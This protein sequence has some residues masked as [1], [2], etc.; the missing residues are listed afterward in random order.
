MRTSTVYNRQSGF[1][2]VE[3]MVTIVVAFLVSAAIWSAYKVQ[4]QNTTIQQQVTEIQQ[5]IRAALETMS[6]EFRLVA[7][8]PTNAGE[9]VIDPSPVSTHTT[10]SFTAD[11]CEDGGAPKP[12]GVAACQPG[13]PYAGQV[14][15]ERYRYQLTDLDGDGVND[16][17]LRITD[18]NPLPINPT[19][20]IAENIE[21]VEFMY[22]LDTGVQA[23]LPNPAI[24]DNVIAVRIAILARSSKPDHNFTDTNVYTTSWG[25]AWNP[26][27]AFLKHRRRMLEK[28]IELRNMGLL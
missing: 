22:I 3:L 16:T 20:V 12:D 6:A 21:Q 1:T 18:V 9:Y 2:L 25:T 26:D 15:A 19:Q 5:N 8:D 28:T 17:L 4:Q 7:Y 24:V 23:P 14:L 11:L 10:F 27:P 13:S